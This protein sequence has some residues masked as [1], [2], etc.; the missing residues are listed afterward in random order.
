MGRVVVEAHQF[1]MAM[2][3]TRIS[4]VRIT[5]GADGSRVATLR[6]TL[7]CHTFAGTAS[8]S[9]GSRTLAEPASFEILAV[10]AG[11]NGGESGDS[12]AFTVFF[13]ATAS[14]VNYAIF[15][16]KPTFTGELVAGEVTIAPAI[17][18]PLEE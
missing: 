9:V 8:V 11:P 12:F 6:G 5:G 1:F 17:A 16:P 10:D 18:M 14:P 2:Y 3:A 15:G 7:D 13:D 4:L